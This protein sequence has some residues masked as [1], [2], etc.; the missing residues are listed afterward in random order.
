MCVCVFV[1]HSIEPTCALARLARL[2]TCTGATLNWLE[3]RAKAPKATSQKPECTRCE[4]L[5]K[6]RKNSPHLNPLER[7]QNIGPLIIGPFH[8]SPLWPD[9]SA[10]CVVRVRAR[11]SP[12]QPTASDSIVSIRSSYCIRA[13]CECACARAKFNCATR[14][15]CGLN[16]LARSLARSSG[17]VANCKPKSQGSNSPQHNKTLDYNYN[18]NYN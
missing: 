9:S 4:Q 14:R 15:L 17:P 8:S 5:A 18:Y 2:F 13:G 6:T 3:R 10:A 7:T 12:S 16:A 1:L 11:R